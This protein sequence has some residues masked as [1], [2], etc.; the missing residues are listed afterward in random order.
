M[1]Y[2]YDQQNCLYVNF[3]F[4]YCQKESHE[5]TGLEIQDLEL[6]IGQT[7]YYI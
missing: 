3:S 7:S 5:N 1:G 6:P 2:V 4:L